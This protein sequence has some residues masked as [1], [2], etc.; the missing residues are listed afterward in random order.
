MTDRLYT[1]VRRFCRVADNTGGLSAI[2]LAY[3]VRCV[4]NLIRGTPMHAQPFLP[5]PDLTQYSDTPSEGIRR[6]PLKLAANR[7]STHKDETPKGGS[8]CDFEVDVQVNSNSAREQY[9]LI[10]ELIALW[11]LFSLF[12]QILGFFYS[13]VMCK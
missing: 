5:A 9:P 12:W 10:L 1:S 2:V 11:N 8:G 13:L 7:T 6:H 4:D 3:P